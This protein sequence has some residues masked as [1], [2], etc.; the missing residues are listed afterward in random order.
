MQANRTDVI[1]GV[2]HKDAVA[3]TLFEVRACTG[4]E[5]TDSE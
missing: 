2:A 1:A 3:L 4:I 5:K